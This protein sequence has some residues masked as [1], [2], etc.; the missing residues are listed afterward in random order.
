MTN[1]VDFMIENDEVIANFIALAVQEEVR[2][3]QMNIYAAVPSDL[4]EARQ[5]VKDS[6][7]PFEDIST[8]LLKHFGVLRDGSKL[9]GLVGLE[10][11][12]EASLLRSLAVAPAWRG[13]GL[14][15]QLT[16]WAEEQARSLGNRWLYLLTTTA[17]EYFVRRGYQKIRREDAPAEIQATVEFKNLCPLTAAC[18]EKE[19]SRV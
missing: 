15:G 7:L 3:D 13:Q 19:L 8:I 2:S 17:E 10:P 18:M 9:I 6:G 4:L 16:N 1:P 14:G 11:F 5:L 12:R